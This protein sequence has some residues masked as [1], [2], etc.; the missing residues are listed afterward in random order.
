MSWKERDVLENLIKKT[1]DG[2]CKKKKN[3]YILLFLK[4][5]IS[6]VF[7]LPNVAEAYF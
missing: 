7:A 5:N 3:I 4:K 6:S 2:K 1:K